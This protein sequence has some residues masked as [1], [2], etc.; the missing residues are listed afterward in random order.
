ME[1]LIQDALALAWAHKWLPLAALVVGFLVRLLK[2]DTALPITVPSQWRATAALV[3]GSVGGVLDSL[4][5]GVDMKTAITT[6][7]SAALVAIAG[8]LVVIEGLFKG[9][10]IG[11]GPLMKKDN[12]D[13]QDP[14]SKGPRIHLA[15]VFLVLLLPGCAGSFEEARFAGGRVG[16]APEKVERCSSLDSTHRTWGGVAKTSA[17]LAGASGLS[18]IATDDQRLDTGLA[19][20]AAAAG[21]VA[22]GAEFVSQDAAASWARECSQ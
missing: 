18:T 4:I 14:P 3:L 19:I 5:E 10:E 13:D 22:V 7:I 21:A 1:Q 17:A 8:H 12:D 15:L 16:A 2:S 6:G 11:L 9:K 20:G